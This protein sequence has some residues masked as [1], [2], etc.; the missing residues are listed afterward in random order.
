MFPHFIRFVADQVFHPSLLPQPQ[1]LASVLYTPP[2]GWSGTAQ[3]TLSVSD[4]GFTGNGG[5]LGAAA[6]FNVVVDPVNAP[7]L[8]LWHGAALSRLDTSNASSSSSSS[9]TSKKSS[10]PSRALSVVEDSDVGLDGCCAEP[11][12]IQGEFDRSTGRLTTTMAVDKGGRFPAKA[13]GLRVTDDA[14]RPFFYFS[15]P[16]LGSF[17]IIIFFACSLPLCPSFVALPGSF[18]T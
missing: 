13:V 4:L 17:I 9:F 3:F 15:L 5:A 7:P 18:G 16:P 10:L 11:A 12:S 1:A 14:V 6:N 8:V 2:V